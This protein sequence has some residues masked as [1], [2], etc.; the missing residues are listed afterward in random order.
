MP[1]IREVLAAAPALRVIGPAAFDLDVGLALEAAE[2]LLHGEQ[3]G[4]DLA[5]VL[6]VRE[7]VDDGHL[8]VAR[9]LHGELGLALGRRTQR[10]RVAEHLG[11]RHLGRRGFGHHRV[12]GVDRRGRVPVGHALGERGEVAGD[13]AVEGGGLGVDHVLQT[14]GVRR[15]HRAG[16]CLNDATG[17]RRGEERGRGG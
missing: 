14:P 7:S 5:G 12:A 13:G 9:E 1:S 17:G 8:G 2:V 3:V 15:T 16:G 4:E 10:R 11:Q 6:Q